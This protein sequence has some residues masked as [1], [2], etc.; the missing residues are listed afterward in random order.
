MSF[1][2]LLRRKSYY[3]VTV[4]HEM[5]V[6]TDKTVAKQIKRDILIF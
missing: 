3:E 5:F 2:K 1:D 6:L 4:Y